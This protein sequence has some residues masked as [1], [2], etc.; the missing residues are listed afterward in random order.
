[1]VVSLQNIQQPQCSISDK[2]SFEIEVQGGNAPYKTKLQNGDYVD[3]QFTFSNLDGGNS[4]TVSVLDANNCETSITVTIDRGVELNLILSPNYSCDSTASIFAIVDD[5]YEGQVTYTINGA[6]P[7]RDGVF[8]D[9]TQGE[10]TIEA[11]HDNGCSETK[12]VTIEE[13]PPVLEF[14]VDKSQEN[15]LIVNAS[16]GVPPYTYSIDNS[17]YGS[18]NEFIIRETRFY[19]LSVRDS[20]GCVV[21]IST[22]G[23]YIDIVIPNFFTPNGN[24]KHDT[25]YP[26]KVKDYHNI[27]VQI[28]DRYSRLLKTFKGVN[29]AWDGNYNNR[30]LPSG[31]YWYVIY[32]NQSPLKRRK[33]MGHFTLYR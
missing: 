9:L 26:T 7:Q 14:T 32:Y 10:Y 25:W 6:N 29:N 5:A 1:M 3:N 18:E 24:G 30:P 23:E 2:G 20:R 11:R 21:G 12:T 15:I 27:E 19:D 22:E 33:L 16:G 13:I 17:G 31:D 8:A 28:Y 4:Y